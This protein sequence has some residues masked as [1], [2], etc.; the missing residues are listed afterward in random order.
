MPIFNSDMHFD[1][2]SPRP[3]EEGVLNC[4]RHTHTQRWTW[5]L[6]DWICTVGLIQ[7]K[8]WCR[9]AIKKICFCLDID[10]FAFTPPP[11]PPPS[12]LDTNK[13]IFFHFRAIHALYFHISSY[14]HK[15]C[16]LKVSYHQDMVKQILWQTWMMHAEQS[17]IRETP[18]LLTDADSRTNINLK[19]LRDFWGSL[20]SHCSKSTKQFVLNTTL[21]FIL[22]CKYEC[23]PIFQNSILIFK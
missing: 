11:P 1:Q 17:R 21:R 14:S 4:H 18:T 6:Y 9:E 10:N 23:K 5:Q 3:P 13:G 7:W 16:C 19:R 22:P 20:P 2:R 8:S 12:F 15:G